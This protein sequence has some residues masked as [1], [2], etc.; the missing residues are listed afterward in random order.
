MTYTT[1]T[2]ALLIALSA[3]P[4]EPDQRPEAWPRG[5]EEVNAQMLRPDM[6][7]K[8]ML[9]ALGTSYKGCKL[10]A[11]SDIRCPL[12]PSAGAT[13]CVLSVLWTVTGGMSTLVTCFWDKPDSPARLKAIEGARARLTFEF[14]EPIKNNPN[15]QALHFGH[16]DYLSAHLSPIGNAVMVS[17]LVAVSRRQQPSLAKN[18]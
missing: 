8:E 10:V 2:V 14:G 5:W 13:Q 17:R 3:F 12:S 9:T 7:P 15:Q 18:N 1:S 16:P 11:A 6:D 4:P